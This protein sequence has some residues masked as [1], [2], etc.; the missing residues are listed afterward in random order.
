MARSEVSLLSLRSSQR[1]SSALGQA[2][3]GSIHRTE[4][5]DLSRGI[6]S[7]EP[8]VNDGTND[9]R[10]SLHESVLFE[11]LSTGFECLAR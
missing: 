1:G 2:I 7:Q 10:L 11:R 9:D 4:F 5:P 3:S 6:R 8:H